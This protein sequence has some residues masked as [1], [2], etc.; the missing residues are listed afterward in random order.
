MYMNMYTYATLASD[1]DQRG[2]GVVV[3][4]GMVQL[5]ID[6][7]HDPFYTIINAIQFWYIR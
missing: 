4:A 5:I 6:I 2:D 1:D 3:V 7:L